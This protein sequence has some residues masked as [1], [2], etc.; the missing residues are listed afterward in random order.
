MGCV[1]QRVYGYRCYV[2]IWDFQCLIIGVFVYEIIV[3]GVVLCSSII[4][5]I[6]D[7]RF[8][9]QDEDGFYVIVVIFRFVRIKNKKIEVNLDI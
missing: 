8:R 6:G 2:V 9:V 3:I 5:R 4:C 1:Q 7:F